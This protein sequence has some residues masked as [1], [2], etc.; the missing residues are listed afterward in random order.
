MDGSAGLSP[1]LQSGIFG[2][3]GIKGGFIS[4]RVRARVRARV[5]A[6][7]SQS[8]PPQLYISALYARLH[9]SQ[10]SL[11]LLKQSRQKIVLVTEQTE[12]FNK[13]M[14]LQFHSEGFRCGRDLRRNKI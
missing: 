1:S 12:L 9:E 3:N 6:R 2:I 13:L 4:D 5:N 11:V 14:E 8:H 7:A 10:T